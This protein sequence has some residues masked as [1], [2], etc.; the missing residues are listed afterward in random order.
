MKRTATLAVL[1]FIAAPAY[2]QTAQQWSQLLDYVRRTA[3]RVLVQEEAIRV[4]KEENTQ[5]RQHVTQ[6]DTFLIDFV[7]KYN[8]LTQNLAN[9]T[10]TE[11]TGKI[12]F[13]QGVSCGK[14]NPTT[15]PAPLY[16]ATLPVP[17]YPTPPVPR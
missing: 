11:P 14:T 4:L 3:E 10:S 1:L 9:A 17:T 12:T 8:L 2:A 7:C 13:I 5:Q 16:P 15:D 6:M